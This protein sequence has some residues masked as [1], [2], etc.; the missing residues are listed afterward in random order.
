MPY[1]TGY[2]DG[3]YGDPSIATGAIPPNSWVPSTTSGMPVTEQSA[4]QLSVFYACVR[5]LAD[6]IACLP[7]DSF[8]KKDNAPHRVDPQPALLKQPH[9]DL[10]VFDWKH[11]MVVSLAIKGNFYGLV[12]ERDALE[13]PANI[14]PLHPDWVVLTRDPKSGLKKAYVNG[15]QVP[16]EDLFHIR[17][18][19]LP[20]YDIGLSPLQVFKQGI[21]LGLAAEEFGG[22]WFRDGAAPSSVLTTDQSLT[23]DQVKATQKEWIASHGGKRRP[24]VLSGGFKW[25]PVTITPEESQF[26]QTRKF[27]VAE[28]ARMF[29]IPPHMVG[30]VD[31]STSWGTG[32]E[33]MAVGFVTFTL[34]PWLTCIEAALNRITPNGQFIKF[35]P[36]GLLRGDVS[37]RYTAYQI[38]IDTGWMNPDEARAYE[39]LPPIPGGEGAK[40]RQPLNFGPLGY[41]PEPGAPIA[42]APAAGPK[43]V[44]QPAK[45][46]AK[47]P[48]K[49]PTK[50]PAP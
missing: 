7:W 37:G 11:E 41:V 10:T 26:L 24:A 21:G 16:L 49:T 2:G 18:F 4:L 30:D 47:T 12:T 1:L 5:L 14:L 22:H 6:S 27:Q 38:A 48:T 32:I 15:Q 39:D 25:E 45:P 42:G 13:Y 19:T 43:G 23:P 33:Q 46:A 36:E 35:N 29:G 9:P 50:T 34:M 40:Y 20:G 44:K 31:R 28:I 17:R 8:R 3:Y